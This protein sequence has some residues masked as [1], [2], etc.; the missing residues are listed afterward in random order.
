MTRATPRRL[1]RLLLRRYGPQAWWPAESPFEV[2]AGA[3]LTQNTN[4]R[5]A[6]RAVARL[7]GAGLLDAE[8]LA[9]RPLRD[10][11]RLAR[12]AGFYRQK[13]RTLAGVASF[14]RDECGG[15]PRR[16]AGGPVAEARERLL[17]LRGVGEETADSI[18]LYAAGAPVFVLDTYTRRIARRHRLG[19]APE[20]DRRLR[21][22]FEGGLPQEAGVLG[23]MHAL[24]VRVGKERCG[25]REPRCGG[26]PLEPLLPPGARPRARATK[27]GC[28]G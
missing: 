15:D 19:G 21:A 7:K 5:N 25:K 27:G 23:E 6:A 8:R 9:A 22:F 11:Q 2:C 3:V 18:L 26:C 20:S 16:L 4:W 10:L 24:L 1:L 13:A 12:P 14:L 28:D 17:A